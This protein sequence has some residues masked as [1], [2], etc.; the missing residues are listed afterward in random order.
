M[1]CAGGGWERNGT[2]QRRGG[3]GLGAALPL[4]AWYT[5]LLRAGS[6]FNLQ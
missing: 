3:E 4:K 2:I 6:S 5:L 1:F